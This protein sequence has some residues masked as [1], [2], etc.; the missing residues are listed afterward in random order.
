MVL[1]HSQ[2]SVVARVAHLLQWCKIILLYQLILKLM[3]LAT[4]DDLAN[5]CYIL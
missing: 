4:S 2:F 3:T 5:H 1:L